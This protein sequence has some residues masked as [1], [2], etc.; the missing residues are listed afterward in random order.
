MSLIPSPSRLTGEDLLR[1]IHSSILLVLK[2]SGLAL[3]VA[4]LER[5][6][7]RFFDI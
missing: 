2:N 3:V 7:S 6:Q 5:S 1:F 4:R